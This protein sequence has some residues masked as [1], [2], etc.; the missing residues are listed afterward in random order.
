MFVFVLCTLSHAGNEFGKGLFILVQKRKRQKFTIVIAGCK[1]GRWVHRESYLI[2][3]LDS[4]KDQS[5]RFAFSF[6]FA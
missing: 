1:Q 4:V 3:T 5:K 6:A 2:S